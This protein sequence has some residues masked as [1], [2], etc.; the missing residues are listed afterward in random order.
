[1]IDRF[2]LL[3]APVKTLFRVTELKL[4]A[5]LAGV[6]KIEAGPQGGRIVFGPEPKVDPAKLVRL[7]QQQHK[8]YRL[9]GRDKLRFIKDSPDAEARAA[10]TV[11]DVARLI[12]RD[13]AH[14][15]KY[16][17]HWTH[18]QPHSQQVGPDHRVADGDI[19][20]LHA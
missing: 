2:G 19:L 16:A 18:G 17:R 9:D 6:K 20:E 10:E 1:M 8:V 7:I 3:P 14:S 11:R 4:R 13:L 5:M 12:H 15:L